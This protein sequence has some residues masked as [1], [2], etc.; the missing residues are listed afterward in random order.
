MAAQGMS[1]G[2]RRHGMT[3]TPLW[4][5]WQSMRQ[6]CNNP[7][8]K[9]FDAYGGRGIKVCERWD[10]FEAFQEDVGAHPGAGLQLDRIDNARGYEPGNVRWSTPAV[11]TRNRRSN[12][13]LTLFGEAKP[14][15]DWAD[16]SRCAVTYDALW[17]RI[18]A[19]WEAERALL[20]P[21]YAERRHYRAA[22]A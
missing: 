14:L 1:H 22:N 19:G 5:V 21:K 18:D 10:S 8:H 2:N 17:K 3:H 6:R 16:D 4:T 20:T 11:Q 7:G 9:S 15:V 13:I 12:V